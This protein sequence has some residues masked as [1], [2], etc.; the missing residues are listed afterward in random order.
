MRFLCVHYYYFQGFKFRERG[1]T[2]IFRYFS[3]TEFFV[4]WFIFP[5]GW[6]TDFIWLTQFMGFQ[7]LSLCFLINFIFAALKL[8]EQATH[9]LNSMQTTSLAPTFPTSACTQEQPDDVK[10][11]LRIDKTNQVRLCSVNLLR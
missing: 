9:V 2:F 8:H 11:L 6:R 1:N 5:F 7:T 4:S 10:P 3:A